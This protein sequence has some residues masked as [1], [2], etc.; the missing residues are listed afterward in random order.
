MA[1][2]TFNS[3]VYAQLGQGASLAP[4]DIKDATDFPMILG[5]STV[6]RLY[7]DASNSL[8]FLGTG[9]RYLVSGGRLV[10][11]TGGTLATIRATVDGVTAFSFTGLSLSLPELYDRI[12]TD[13]WLGVR[14]YL[15]SS[16]D[17]ITGTSLGDLLYAGAGNDT[18]QGG[19]G[20]DRL[21]SEDGADRVLGQLGADTLNGGAGN[22]TLIGGTGHDVLI[23]GLGADAFVFAEAGLHSDRITDFNEVQDVIRLDGDALGGFAYV[24][25]L[26]G[27]DFRLG[28]VA[29]DAS[30]RLMYQKATGQLWFDADGVGGRAN[31][32]LA[33]L[34]DGTNLSAADIIII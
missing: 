30:D 33:D 1:V 9:F 34:A 19:G 27:A 2:I 29:D 25:Q 20:A 5:N 18:L 11:I 32:L 21:F 26:R 10:D 13:N 3:A 8:E 22:D 24:G 14:N 31:V 16:R 7:E 12:A 23:G 17:T 28:A 6:L 15:L 4:V